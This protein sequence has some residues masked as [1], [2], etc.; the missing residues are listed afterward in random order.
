MI[1]LPDIPA[2]MSVLPFQFR[3]TE[4]ILLLI[5][6][7]LLWFLMPGWLHSIDETAG[8]IS[9]D[10]WM[11]LLLSLIS[12]I[13][14]LTICWWLLKRLW[15]GAGLPTF[16]QMVLQFKTLPIWQQLSFYWGS[17]ALLLL[18]ALGC[19]NAIF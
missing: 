6:L 4:P 11:L 1:R 12:F 19:L 17:F 5:V 13:L 14:I 2:G 8:N 16:N 9:Q 3:K 10:I 7:L 18:T 15:A